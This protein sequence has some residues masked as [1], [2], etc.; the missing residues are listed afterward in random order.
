MIVKKLQRTGTDPL[1]RLQ[2]GALWPTLTVSF[3]LVLPLSLSFSVSPRFSYSL[4]RVS[5][6]LRAPLVFLT[7]PA[8]V[9][10]V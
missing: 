4:A 8:S 3:S 7:I 6:K 2:I 9:K 1:K 10:S 5:Q